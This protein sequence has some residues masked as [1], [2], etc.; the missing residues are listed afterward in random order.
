[1][2]IKFKELNGLR[3][4]HEM[5]LI[6]QVK[7]MVDYDISSTEK[8]ALNSTKKQCWWLAVSTNYRQQ[9]PPVV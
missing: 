6:F 2:K 5:A 4:S 8:I 1:M 3:G 9:L 7:T